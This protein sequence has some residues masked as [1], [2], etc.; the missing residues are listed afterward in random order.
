M[1]QEI[2]DEIDLKELW[3]IL[4]NYRWLIALIIIISFILGMIYLKYQQPIYSAYSILK[5]NDNGNGK[6]RK[7]EDMLLN[8]QSTLETVNTQ[9]DISLLKTFYINNQALNLNKAFFKIQYFIN[10]DEVYDYGKSKEKIPIEIDDIEILD[11]NILGKKITLTPTNSGDGYRIKIKNSS[12]EK[13]LGENLLK[14]RD[15]IY[16]YNS[17]ITTKYFKIKIKKLANFNYKIDFNINGDN[18]YIYE[19]II[20]Q[21]LTISQVEKEVPIIKISYKDNIRQR[22]IAYV[23]SLSSSF[24]KESIINKTEQS[25]KVLTFITK[26]LNKMKEKLKKSER[27]LEIYRVS[28]KVIEPS[29]QASTFIRKLSEMDIELSENRLKESLIESIKEFID[30]NHNIGAVAPALMELDEKPT[31]KLI[32]TLQDLELKRDKLLVE[33]TPKHP[34]VMEVNNQISM[35]KRKIKSNIKNIEKQIFKKSSNLRKLISSYDIKL[36]SLPSKERRLINI[37]R[38]YEVSSNMYNFLLKK[39]TENEIYKVSTLSD[40][41]VIDKAYSSPI[42]V[43]PKKGIILVIFSLI[44]LITS[45]II[46]YWHNSITDKVR[47]IEQIKNLIKFPI[48]ATIKNEKNIKYNNIYSY[49]N[50]PIAEDYRTLRTNLKLKLDK[51]KNNKGK[52]ILISS[53]SR[54]EKKDMVVVNLSTIFQMANYKV[55][56]LELDLREPILHRIFNIKNINKD[57]SSYLRGDSE[58]E[59][60]IYD[61]K[62]DNLQLIPAKNIPSNPSELILSS[63]LSKLIDELENYY[64]YIIINS[65]PFGNLADTKYIIKYSDIFLS[66]LRENISQK[67]SILELNNLIEEENIKN[68]GAIFIKK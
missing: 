34:T 7:L 43:S 65:T 66:V 11:K 16:R 44:G 35:L 68:I 49:P 51:I 3:I 17:R 1:K 31:L 39:K 13:L 26:E 55:V 27:A 53:P 28:H 33:L 41:R 19:K 36:K 22:A 8:P 5:V 20:K 30:R 2:N 14:L 54:E 64:N 59:D 58:I 67:S 38:D 47:Y 21:N 32:A 4:L 46:A 48:Y 15:K 56:V 6:K 62:Y 9:E 45:I 40:Y 29:I 57:I 52:V 24:I 60:I 63:N 61:T 10:G 12:L 42:P 25:K 18:R 37:K 23:D 50:S